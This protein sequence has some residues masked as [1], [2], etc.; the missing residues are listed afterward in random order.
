M[1]RNSR[2]AIRILVNVLVQPVGKVIAVM[3]N[4]RMVSTVQTA[5]ISASVV[6]HRQLVVIV[7]P[8]PVNAIRGSLASSA[9]HCVLKVTMA[10][11]VHVNAAIA[12][13][14]TNVM[15]LSDA[16]MLTS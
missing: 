12:V 14:V 8:A 16:V 1:R 9:T 10:Y 2:N 6:E 11:A 15:L 4:A 5:S 3:C 7:S 13:L